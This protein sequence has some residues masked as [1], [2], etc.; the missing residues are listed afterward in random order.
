MAEVSLWS[1]YINYIAI[2]SKLVTVVSAYTMEQIE[3]VRES[4]HLDHHISLKCH[5][6]F[7]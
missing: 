3:T 4:L 7:K 1:P 6:M 2:S 5:A